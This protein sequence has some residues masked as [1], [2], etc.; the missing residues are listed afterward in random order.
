[1]APCCG[2]LPEIRPFTP[3]ALQYRW[4]VLDIGFSARKSLGVQASHR[5]RNDIGAFVLRNLV[6]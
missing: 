1:M 3:S 4:S 2:P 5:Y 6:S